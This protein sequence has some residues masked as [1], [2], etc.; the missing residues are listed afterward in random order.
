MVV[1]TSSL[2]PLSRA[3]GRWK[4]TQPRTKQLTVAPF[5]PQQLHLVAR[6]RRTASGALCCGGVARQEHSRQDTGGL[7][8]KAG[9]F[10]QITDRPHTSAKQLKQC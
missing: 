1:L 8:D 4:L 5:S 9:L 10:R 7:S 2:Q 3:Q 6:P